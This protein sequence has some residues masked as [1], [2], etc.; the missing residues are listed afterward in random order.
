MSDPIRDEIELL[1]PAFVPNGEYRVIL[2]HWKKFW[3]FQRPDLVMWF[4]IRDDND[5]YGEILPAYYRVTWN[6]EQFSAGWKTHFCRD[7]QQ[8][9]GAVDSTDQF[10]IE[11]FKGV[12]FL[13]EAREVKKDQEQRPLGKVNQYSR[14]GRLL[15]VVA[16]LDESDQ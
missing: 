1:R 10:E 7:Y 14:I 15:G 8:C 16:S 5:Y 9:F 12:V 4:E 3:H 13:A 6:G 11:K 2:R